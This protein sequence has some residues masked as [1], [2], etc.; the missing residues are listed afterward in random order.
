M[1]LLISCTTVLTPYLVNEWDYTIV[2][3]YCNCRF[4][5]IRGLS[6][7]QAKDPVAN[8]DTE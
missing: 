3:I 2:E 7:F 8:K 4:M 6:V 5:W 1:P